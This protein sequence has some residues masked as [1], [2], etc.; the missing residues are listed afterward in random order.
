MPYLSCKYSF[1]IFHLSDNYI[2]AEKSGKTMH[3]LKR[4]SKRIATGKQ[5]KKV[6]IL[7]TLKDWQNSQNSGS[8]LNS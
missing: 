2:V 5:R 7:G 8:Q 4:G 3:L 6:A 1:V